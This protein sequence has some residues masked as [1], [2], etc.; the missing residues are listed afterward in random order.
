MKVRN[1]V[2]GI[3][4]LAFGNAQMAAAAASIR[5]TDDRWAQIEVTQ[6]D[7]EFLYA[8]MAVPEK[9]VGCTSGELCSRY[10]KSKD[11][12]LLCGMTLVP[13]VSYSC[14]IALDASSGRITAFPEKN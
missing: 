3:A 10:K 11:G 6:D 14:V 2:Y 4:L 5:K 8:K 7:A 12:R 1:V 13:E 9:D